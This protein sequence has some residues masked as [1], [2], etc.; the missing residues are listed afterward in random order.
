TKYRA[1]GATFRE[2]GEAAFRSGW[3]LTGKNNGSEHGLLETTDG[4]WLPAESLVIA[5]RRDDPGGNAVAGRKWID[6]SIKRQMLVAYEGRKPAYAT[7]VSTGIG[8]LGD[9]KETHATVRGLFTIHAKH[10]SATMDGDEATD[11]YDLRDVP[12]IQY[13]FEGYALHGAFWHD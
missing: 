2:D 13:F 3:V 1:E 12:Y 11:S 5:E 4:V 8:G 9:P 6:V 7:L 10:V